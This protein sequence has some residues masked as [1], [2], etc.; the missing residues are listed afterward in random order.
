MC[1]YIQ[2]TMSTYT[3]ICILRLFSLFRP[4]LLNVSVRLSNFTSLLLPLLPYCRKEWILLLG[5]KA[6]FF[7]SEFSLTS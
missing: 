4:L 1:T 7:L 3:C 2:I 6:F 5:T